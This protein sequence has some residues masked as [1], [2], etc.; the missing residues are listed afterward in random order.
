MEMILVLAWEWRYVLI[1][2][3]ALLVYSIAEWGKVK[4]ILAVYI[5][6]ARELA[7]KLVLESGA[8]QEDWVV[9]HVWDIIPLVVKTPMEVFGGKELLR[10]IVKIAYNRTKDYLDNGIVDGS[11]PLEYST[12]LIVGEVW[13]AS[14]T[15]L[16]LI[17]KR[18][19]AKWIE[20]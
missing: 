8:E 19:F 14:P 20:Q 12:Q 11:I 18:G 9:E 7:K 3:A 13:L 6:R 15:I 4:T 2:I 16:K 1:A 17:G 10:K 5:T